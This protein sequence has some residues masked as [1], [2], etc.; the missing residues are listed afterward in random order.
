MGAWAWGRG[1]RWAVSVRWGQSF[2]LGK[3]S[4]LEMDGGDGC[5]AKR[6]GLITPTCALSDR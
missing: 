1:W 2:S 4:I 5:T 6:M 3:W